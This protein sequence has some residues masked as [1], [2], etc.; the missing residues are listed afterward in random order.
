MVVVKKIKKVR[1]ILTR[2]RNEKKSIGFVPTMGYFHQGHLRLM[3]LARKEN[4]YV[5]V[6]IFVNPLQ[7]GPKEDFKEYP[8]D[9][10]RDI[11]MAEEVGVDLIFAPS[12][13]EMY[14]ED[15]STYI[16]VTGNLTQ[17]MC[18][19]SRPG[20]FKG[21]TTVVGKLFNIVQPDRAYFGK[22]DYQQL[23]IVKKM[24][25]D[26]NFPLKI[27]AVN[28]VREKD[29][30]AMSSRNTYLN[31]KSRKKALVLYQSLKLA[32][33]EIKKGVKDPKIIKEKMKNLIEEKGEI[34][35]ISIAD[36]QTL[37]EV[38]KI[39]KKVLVALA[40]KIDGVRLI[41]NRIIG[42]N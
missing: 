36:P 39:E 16:E 41:D 19:K 18:G 10:K 2:V 12:E 13:K 7:F 17:V 27:V 29:K 6:S 32:E 21:V 25:K 40:V 31:E 42:R 9:L 20:H 34:D 28:T 4:D 33:K 26:L 5:V 1:E 37:Q 24:V 15:F 30:L 11:K 23:I 22:K 38:E 14:E 35:Y 3:E 8:R